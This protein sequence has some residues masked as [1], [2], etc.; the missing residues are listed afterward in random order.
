ML[1]LSN[2][3]GLDAAA[4]G[5]HAGHHRQVILRGLAALILRAALS[6]PAIALHR[7]IVAESS[8]FPY[9]GTV[10]T[11]QGARAEAIR[12]IAGV[13]EREAIAGNITLDNATFAA[14]QFLHMVIA[15]PQ[16]R[17]MGLGTPMTSAEVDA[18]SRDV[19]NLF[20]NG[21]RNWERA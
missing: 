17:A 15:E 19:V 7:L 2:P 3:D 12:L 18:W 5:L 4:V 11:K 8:R 16:S 13:L 1:Y 14:Q 10:V 20:V 21:C 6:P 9:L